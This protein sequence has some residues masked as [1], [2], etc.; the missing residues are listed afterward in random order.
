[1]TLN[2]F[3][4]PLGLPDEEPLPPRD[5]L[6]ATRRHAIMALIV[7]RIGK[8]ECLRYHNRENMPGSAFDEWWDARGKYGLN[9]PPTESR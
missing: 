6:R 7:D 1:M 5:A 8:K 3:E 4:W 2:H 9:D